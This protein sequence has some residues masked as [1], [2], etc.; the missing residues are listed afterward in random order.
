MLI[1]AYWYKKIGRYKIK[2]RLYKGADYWPLPPKSFYKNPETIKFKE[3]W[4]L[5]Y[6]TLDYLN[7]D[8]R[9]LLEVVTNFNQ[10]IFDSYQ[11]NAIK[12]I[13]LPSLAYTIFRANF[14]KNVALD[15]LISTG[16]PHIKGPLYSALKEGYYGGLVDTY[17]TEGEDQ[18][19]YDV[20]S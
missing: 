4:N 18:F 2:I 16:I 10:T 7:R 3:N 8:I 9:A 14:H 17:I 15:K 1:L 13:T 12:Y 6:Q 20:N 19:Y 11:I 5:R